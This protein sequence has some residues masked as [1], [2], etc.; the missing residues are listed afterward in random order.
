MRHAFER[1]VLPSSW[2]GSAAIA[3]AILSAAPLHASAITITDWGL[4]VVVDGDGFAFDFTNVVQNPFQGSHLAAPP[5]HA[6]RAAAQYDISW[7]AE[8][9]DFNISAQLAAQDGNSVRSLASGTIYLQTDADLTLTLDAVLNYHLPSYGLDAHMSF[10]VRD[11]TA[12]QYILGESRW[13]STFSQPP[14]SG[15]LSMNPSVILP[16]DHQFRVQYQM[17]VQTSGASLT[18]ATADGHVAFTIT[19]EPATLALFALPLALLRRRRLAVSP[20]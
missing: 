14:G 19:P 5:G 9:G 20:L 4:S 11:L 7:L 13:Y 3:A 2:L 18:L 17:L 10:S 1:L 8:F 15:V 16:A 12:N 6:S